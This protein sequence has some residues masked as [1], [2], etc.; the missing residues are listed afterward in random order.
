MGALPRTKMNLQQF[1]AWWDEQPGDD[2]YELVDG[3]VVA[4]VRDRV[5]HN[6]AKTRIQAAL[7]DAI[8]SAGLDCEAF[9]DG[10]GVSEGKHNFRLPDAAVNCG[11]IDAD[12][13][14]LPNP[15]ILV[16][17][18]S[19]TSEARD[20]HEKLRDYFLIPS[21]SHYVIVYEDRG[22]VVHHRRQGR[23]TVET[24]FVSSGSLNL[25]PPGLS[26]PVAAFLG[27]AGNRKK[28]DR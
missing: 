14:I 27:E 1:F 20:V 15:V 3:Q 7:A 10:I 28:V 23:E 22:Y 4:M 16:E 12:A 26:V 17:I 25:D 21:V 2:R 18:V 9:V 8:A 19:P 5:R 11:P 24:A 6:R 13:S